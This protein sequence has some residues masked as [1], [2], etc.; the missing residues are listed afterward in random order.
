VQSHSW[1][2]SSCLLPPV[3]VTVECGLVTDFLCCNQS[4]FM[5]L[6]LSVNDRDGVASK[7]PCI[8]TCVKRNIGKDKKIF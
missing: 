7:P 8:V 4:V 3:L 2:R 5:F 1:Q 6:R